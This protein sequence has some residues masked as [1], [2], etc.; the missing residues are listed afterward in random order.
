MCSSDARCALVALPADDP[1]SRDERVEYAVRHAGFPAGLLERPPRGKPYFPDAA[2][3]RFSVSHS[4]AFWVCAV[5]AFEVGVDLQ[6][7]VDCPAGRIARRFFHPDEADWLEAHPDR[8]FD[9]WTAKEAYVKFTGRGI[10]EQFGAFS[11]IADGALVPP[12][13]SFHRFLP[14]A[15]GYSC[16]VCA[17]C[18]F[19]IEW[20]K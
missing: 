19:E 5:A 4:G 10:G 18:E 15:E 14:F 16:C 13:G 17:G 2:E 7:H 12:P 1:R 3:T 6:R 9:V 11:C 8:F 20:V